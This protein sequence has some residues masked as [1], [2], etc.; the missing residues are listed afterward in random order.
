MRCDDCGHAV[1]EGGLV[2]LARLRLCRDCSSSRERAGRQLERAGP[3]AASTPTTSPPRREIVT[4]A[5]F[6]I[7]SPTATTEQ[8]QTERQSSLA[9]LDSEPPVGV[10]SEPEPRLGGLKA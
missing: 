5:A 6:R 10:A 8:I 2:V 3:A 1:R 7:P 4:R 9:W